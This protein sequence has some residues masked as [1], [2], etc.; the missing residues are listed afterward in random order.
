MDEKSEVSEKKVDCK[1]KL[2]MERL[3]K[4]LKRE[5]LEKNMS[6][7]DL[8]FYSKTTESVICNL[9]NAKKTGISIY[10]LVKITESLG[11]SICSLL[12]K[13]KK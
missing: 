10:T 13:Q 9:E 1:I 8:A 7:V 6:R 2:I 3:S 12:K 11:I 5:R 4:N